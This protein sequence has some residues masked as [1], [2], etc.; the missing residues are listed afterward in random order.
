MN[1]LLVQ[2]GF[3]GDVILSTPVIAAIKK[4]YPMCELSLLTTPIAAPLLKADTRLKEVIVFD[5]RKTQGGFFGLF[6]MASLLKGKKYDIVF[7][8]HKSQRTALLLFLSGIKK[9]FGFKEASFSFLYSQTSERSDLSHDVL[10]NLAILRS[11]GVDPQKVASPLVLE[12]SNSAKDAVKNELAKVDYSP[13]SKT[14]V[15]IAPGSVWLTKRW[16]TEGFKNLVA[17]LEEANFKAVLIGGPADVEMAEDIARDSTT[18]INMCGKLSIDQSVALINQV[19]VMVS[20][21]SSPLHMSS[22]T[23]TPVVAL[24]CATIPEFGYGPWMVPNRIVEVKGLSCRPCGRHG[25]MTCPVGTHACRKDITSEQ[26][27]EAVCSLV[28]E[29]KRVQRNS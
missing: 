24:F 22:A 26:V 21:D 7:S 16:T 19:D 3:I 5:K 28:E 10:R 12:T 29:N 9:R 25:G 11:V 23:Q 4:H 13:D 6:K 14:V 8:L 17:L 15:G 27:F 1:I 18:A 20:N 2:T